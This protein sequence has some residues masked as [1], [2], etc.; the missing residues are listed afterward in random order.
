MLYNVSYYVSVCFQ[1]ANQRVSWTARGLLA[2]FAAVV[3]ISLILAWTDVIKWLDFL[4]Y[5]SYVKLAITLIKYVPQVKLQNCEKISMLFQ[6]A[7][8]IMNCNFMEM[9]YCYSD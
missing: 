6:K 3:V 2:V 5:C 4:S 1:R 7:L 9:V 8:K